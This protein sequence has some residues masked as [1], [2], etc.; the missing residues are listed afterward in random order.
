MAKSKEALEAQRK[1]ELEKYGAKPHEGS[2]SL[3]KKYINT[4]GEQS[5][6]QNLGHSYRHRSYSKMSGKIP[7]IPSKFLGE[8]RVKESQQDESHYK[9]HPTL[10][11]LNIIEHPP[12]YSKQ[13]IE[14]HEVTEA[15]H[16]TSNKIKVT[17]TDERA[18]RKSSSANFSQV[19]C[20]ERVAQQVYSKQRVIPS[21]VFGK[22]LSDCKD[23]LILAKRAK[24]LIQHKQFPG[25]KIRLKRDFK[26][27]VIY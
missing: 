25:E 27:S 13:D 8:N 21:T 11:E 7:K 15:S 22:Y 4:Q 2:K 26:S 19:S 3:Q 6:F 18:L 1:Q 23:G 17:K 24:Q 12:K 20:L 9:K 16:V 10:E 5:G 14:A